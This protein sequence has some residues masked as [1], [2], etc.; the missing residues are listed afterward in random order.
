MKNPNLMKKINLKLTVAACLPVAA[1]TLA[2]CSSEPKPAVQTSSAVGYQ[3][4]V[5]GGYMTATHKL[6]ATVT[7]IDAAT[8]K[9]TLETAE[10]SETTVTCGPNVIN[11]DQIRVN[12]RLTVTLTEEVVAFMADARTPA[13]GGAAVVARAPRGAKPGGVMADTVQVTAKVAGI[14]YR[15]HK[16]TLQFPNGSLR[17]VVVRPD[18]D[19]RQR[20]VGEEVVLRITEVMAV[21]VEKPD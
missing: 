17:T 11:F 6:T 9:V 4:G 15:N 1:L 18:V 20:Q 21:K 13:D 5:P 14:D 12:D 7:A 8:R 16:A 3:P 10:G 2:S 19:L